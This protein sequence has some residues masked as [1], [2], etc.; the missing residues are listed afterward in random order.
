[1]PNT[2]VPRREG[3]Y[4]LRE[5]RWVVRSYAV[6]FRQVHPVT[7]MFMRASGG[8]PVRCGIPVV[9]SKCSGPAGDGAV[10]KTHGL[11][12]AGIVPKRPLGPV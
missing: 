6:A 10:A 8:R 2:R 12:A 9:F 3:H 7:G 5:R 11:V 4:Q 1:M